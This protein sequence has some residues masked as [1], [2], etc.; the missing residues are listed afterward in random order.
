DITDDDLWRAQGIPFD[1]TADPD[2]TT[3]HVGPGARLS[4]REG[5]EVLGGTVSSEGILVAHG[6]PDSPVIFDAATPTPA[7][8][9]WTGVEYAPGSAGRLVNA[10][11]RHAQIGVNVQSDGWIQVRDTLVHDC[12]EDGI[13]AGGEAVPLITGCTVRDNGRWGL[14]VYHNA[15]PLLGAAA[16]AENPGLNTFVNNAEYDLA[17]QTGR[18]IVAQ[19]NWWGTTSQA[20]IGARILDQSESAGLGPVNFTPFLDSAPGGASAAAS[21][22]A[23][24]LAIRSVAAVPT[25]TGA[26]VHVALSRPAEVRITVCNIAGRTVRRIGAQVDARA[27]VPWDGRD[28]RGSRAPAG[29]YLIAVEALADD[30]QRSRALTT[31]ALRR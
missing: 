29:R 2:A 3:L 5:V 7:P 23:P 25:G 11:V 28:V 31:V 27:V 30:G 8:G 1:L 6:T 20:E 14:S 16:G 17:N 22:S 4:L 24:P 15:E 18:P 9:D 21:S 10:V 12:S 13:R 26:A 19:N